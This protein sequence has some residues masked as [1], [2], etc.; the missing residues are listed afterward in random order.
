MSGDDL[1]RAANRVADAAII[2]VD[3]LDAGEPDD[4]IDEAIAMMQRVADHAT[5][6]HAAMRA[7]RT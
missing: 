2:V 1:R 5:T 7:G 6:V 3:A 4:Q